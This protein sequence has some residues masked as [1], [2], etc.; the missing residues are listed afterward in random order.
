MR[1]IVLAGLAVMALATPASAL[2]DQAVDELR[3]QVTSPRATE[4]PGTAEA[5]KQVEIGRSITDP[6][7][8]L[9]FVKSLADYD[10]ARGYGDKR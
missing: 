9:A 1:R 4:T 6:D 8:Y 5:R 7:Q 10:H 2:P 3:S